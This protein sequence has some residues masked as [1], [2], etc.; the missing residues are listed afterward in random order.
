MSFPPVAGQGP[1]WHQGQRG[2]PSFGQRRSWEVISGR[3]LDDDIGLLISKSTNTIS[4][5]SVT[6]FERK[7]TLTLYMFLNVKFL[8]LFKQALT[9]KASQA[10]KFLQ[11]TEE[12]T[13][14]LIQF[15]CS[16]ARVY[17]TCFSSQFFL[18]LLPDTSCHVNWV[19]TASRAK[20]HVFSPLSVYMFKV[21][22]VL[23]FFFNLILSLASS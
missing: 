22:A 13:G 11:S 19:C 8:W 9:L 20:V 18:N 21:L 3:R 6:S 10:V 7:R 14:F 16:L 17:S 5:A 2:G 4:I 23:I 1:L 15:S 12:S